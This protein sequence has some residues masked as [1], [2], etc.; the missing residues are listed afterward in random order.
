[1][2]NSGGQE[3]DKQRQSDAAAK[4]IPQISV[5]GGDLT[6]AV[7]DLPLA[8][9]HDA[10]EDSR[11]TDPQI[12]AGLRRFDTAERCHEGENRDWPRMTWA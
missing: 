3:G 7:E 12:L 2:K 6:P 1:M 8:T 9:T 4:E 5:A 11:E 10:K